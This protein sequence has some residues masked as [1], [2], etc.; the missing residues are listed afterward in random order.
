MEVLFYR[1][2]RGYSQ[3]KQAICTNDGVKIDGPHNVKQEWA[4]A[5][6]VTEY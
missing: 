1:D 3:Y 4:Y 2:C 5:H 6:S